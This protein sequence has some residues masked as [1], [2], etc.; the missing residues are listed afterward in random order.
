MNS[1][2]RLSE[3]ITHHPD[4]QINRINFI[5]T[6]YYQYFAKSNDL[7]NMG[8]LYGDLSFLIKQKFSHI[9]CLNEE[10]REKNIITGT[11]KYQDFE[12]SQINYEDCDLNNLTKADIVFN[13][14]LFYHLNPTR[15]K[16]VL[17]ASINRAKKIVF[18][19][20]EVIDC[21]NESCFLTTSGTVNDEDQA[22][23]EKEIKPSISLIN[24]VLEEAGYDYD[25]I[26]SPELNGGIHTYDWKIKNKKTWK[27]G[28]RKFWVIKKQNLEFISPPKGF[29]NSLN[30][31]VHY[32]NLKNNFQIELERKDKELHAYASKLEEEINSKNQELSK[33]KEYTL[34]LEE[35]IT[36]KNKFITKLENQLKRKK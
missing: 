35:E 33:A 22:L 21:D 30:T 16:D 5:I 24:D 34:K 9:S 25:F 26:Q 13:M 31:T 1:K 36:S 7:V 20:T 28:R 12:W 18:F 6:K 17:L 14:G 10:G 8:A 27:R 15:A 29:E 23:S 11:K 19:E 32:S 4:W 2:I 3:I